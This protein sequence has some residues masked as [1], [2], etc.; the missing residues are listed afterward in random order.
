MEKQDVLLISPFLTGLG[1]GSALL[2]LISSSI[3][4]TEKF[5][6][7][8]EAWMFSREKEGVSNSL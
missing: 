3:Y 8:S 1:L 2:N 4:C 5:I 6:K 7:D